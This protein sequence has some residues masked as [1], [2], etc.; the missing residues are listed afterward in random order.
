[1][2]ERETPW[3]FARRTARWLL[4]DAGRSWTGGDAGR[5]TVVVPYLRRFGGGLALFVASHPDA[6]HVGGAAR[7]FWVRS[8]PPRTAMRRS[9]GAASRTAIRSPPPSRSAC[10]GR[11]A[12]AGDS[13]VDRWCARPFPRARLGMV[14]R[15][16]DV[17]RGEHV[18]LV[19]YGAV[20]FLLTGDADHAEESWLLAHAGTRTARRRAEGGAPRQR[21]E[22]QRALSRCRASAPRARLRRRGKLLRPSR[23]RGD[24]RSADRGATVLRTDQLGTHRRPYGWPLAVGRAGERPSQLAN[25]LTDNQ[26]RNRPVTRGSTVAI[27]R[28]WNALFPSRTVVR[29]LSPHS[30]PRHSPLPYAVMVRHTATSVVTI[31]RFIIEQEGLYPGGHR[32]AVGHPVRPRASRRR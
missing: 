29:Q 16:A 27:A 19:Q 26:R 18:A 8:I 12:Q 2:S 21:D 10:H 32:Q 31:E 6:D 20:R 23:R 14:G 1:M 5:A 4:V 22:Q 15:T 25:A 17:E 13:M 7:P 28:R 30:P 24:A 3:R 9:P 11:R